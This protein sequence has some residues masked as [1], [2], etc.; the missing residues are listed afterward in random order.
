MKEAQD[1]KLKAKQDKLNYDL[2]NDKDL[3]D[4][5]QPAY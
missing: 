5:I 1:K 2:K 3:A 4:Y